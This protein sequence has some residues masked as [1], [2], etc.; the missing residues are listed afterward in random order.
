MGVL[1]LLSMA[2]AAANSAQESVA[3]RDIETEADIRIIVDAFYAAVREDDLLNPIFT[4]FAKVDWAHHLPKMYAFWSGL[5]LGKEGYAGR[6]FP[7]HVPLP[8]SREHFSRWLA[9]FHQTV[10]NH[11]SGTFAKRAKDAAASIAH[12]FAIRLGHLDPMAGQLL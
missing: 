8:V 10:D 2:R 9:L 3:M 6:P 7:P 11:Y 4:D 1:L 5:V 12:T